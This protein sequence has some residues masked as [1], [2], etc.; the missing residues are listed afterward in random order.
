MNLTLYEHSNLEL[1][2]ISELLFLVN[3]AAMQKKTTPWESI[4][5][6]GGWIYKRK[7]PL[8]FLAPLQTIVVPP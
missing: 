5:F 4:D 3:N 7:S 1:F 8:T 6:S 2:L